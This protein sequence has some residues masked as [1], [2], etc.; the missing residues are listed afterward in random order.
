MT[1]NE[2]LVIL[3]DLGNEQRKQMY[4]KNGAGENTYGVLLGELRKLA[5]QLGTNHELA[6]EL[7]QSGNTDAQW[8]ACMLFDAKKLS[9]DEAQ[10]MVSQLT[11]SDI[12]DK[13]VGE[14]VC[15][16]KNADILAK[17][18]SASSKDN[19]GR[20]GW[21]LIVYKISDGKLTNIALEELLAT[22]ESELQTATPGKQWAMNHALSEIGIRHPQFTERCITLGEILG[23]YRDLKVPKGCTSAYAPNWIAAG[24]KKS[25]NKI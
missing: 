3:C 10:S 22:I 25:K 9:L 16:H 6:L 13:F 5:K 24:I 2:I 17:E 11:C 20:A 8:L 14:V 12:I 19:L 7:W 23:V 4:I 1:K 18:W 15:N 21:N